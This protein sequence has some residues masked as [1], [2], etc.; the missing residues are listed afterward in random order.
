MT[1]SK[2]YIKINLQANLLVKL[3]I[4]MKT[5]KLTKLKKLN[6]SLILKNTTYLWQHLIA[7]PYCFKTI[8]IDIYW[9]KMLFMWIK[10]TCVTLRLSAQLIVIHPHR[11]MRG[12]YHQAEIIADVFSEPPGR[13]E[14]WTDR[15]STSAKCHQEAAHT[16]MMDLGRR[17]WSHWEPTT[18]TFSPVSH[19]GPVHPTRHSHSSG[20]AH[21]PPFW[22]WRLHTTV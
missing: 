10:T 4:K 13:N 7:S 14:K 9:F 11:L 18:H 20:D 1:K 12:S 19:D 15:G 2:N 3:T 21:F 17:D 5:W 6:L 8:S 16:H 22:Q